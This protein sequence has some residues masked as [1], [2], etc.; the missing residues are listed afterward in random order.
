MVYING[1]S[2]HLQAGHRSPHRAGAQAARQWGLEATLTAD[3]L[4]AVQVRHDAYARH[5]P[6]LAARLRAPEPDDTADDC[7]VLLA[8][9]K[10]DQVPLGTMRV[11]V[12]DH[13][14]L[15]MEQRIELPRWL[16]GKRLAD[17]RRLA[18][19]QGQHAAG[20]RIALCK[21][22]FLR[23]HTQRVDWSLVGARPPLNKMYERLLFTDIL[24]GGSYIPDPVFNE[25]HQALAFE[26]AKGAKRYAAARHPPTWS[27]PCTPTSTSG[28][29]PRCSDRVPPGH[30]SA[31]YY[32]GAGMS[33]MPWKIFI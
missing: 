3:L 12:N 18:V 24:D 7:F 23:L 31:P 14:P 33:A 9:R 8:E 29:Q 20:V 30:P 27:T 5:K 25:P 11:Q 28:M 16:Q 22:S 19:A 17:A 4:K 26:I 6:A 1:L 10:L 13:R 2:A 15:P 21:A 32:F